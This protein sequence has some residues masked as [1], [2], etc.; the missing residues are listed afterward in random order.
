[1]R[2]IALGLF[3]LILMAV[4]GEK[5]NTYL[6][7][8]PK[9]ETSIYGITLEEKASDVLFKHEGFKQETNE[10]WEKK[11]RTLY[12]NKSGTR[13]RETSIIVEDNRVKR[14]VYECEKDSRITDLNSVGN[15]FCNDKSEKI[16]KKYAD[17]V[18]IFCK[19]D[20]YT[21][22]A[23]NIKKYGVRFYLASN[24]VIGTLV[25]NPIEIASISE[26]FSK[27]K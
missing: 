1:L 5:I 3:I 7:N 20:D 17:E 2:G 27:C 16:V 18:E 14:I 6:E 4:V 26:E 21:L 10:H 22:R 24:K 25:A 12:A 23:Y 13:S 9:L 19:N 11:N 15:I 8:L